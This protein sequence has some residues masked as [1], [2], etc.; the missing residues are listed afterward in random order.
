MSLPT[1]LILRN[2]NDGTTANRDF[3]GI[4]QNI[5]RKLNRKMR[6][7]RLGAEA[8]NVRFAEILSSERQGNL[9]SY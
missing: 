2:S 6:V 9:A 7:G 5:P 8:I 4:S 3:N 1:R